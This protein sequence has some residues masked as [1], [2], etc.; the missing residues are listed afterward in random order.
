MFLYPS[1]IFHRSPLAPKRWLLLFS[2]GFFSCSGSSVPKGVL[3]PD[4]ME[5]VLYDVIRV[6]ELVDFRKMTGDSTYRLFENRTALYD[7]VFQLH[8][9]KKDEFQKSLRFY[10]SRPDLVKE[11]LEDLQKK[12]TDTAQQVKEPVRK[13]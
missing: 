9:V 2:I 12:V 10:Q 13:R 8:T 5:A 6:D 1:F 4:K 3:P 7:T 11:I